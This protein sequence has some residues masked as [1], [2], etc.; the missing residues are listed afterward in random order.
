MYIQDE[1]LYQE[2]WGVH[3]FLAD[4]D[5]HGG[6]IDAEILTR[7]KI[8]VG[9]YTLIGNNVITNKILKASIICRPAGEH[10]ESVERCLRKALKFSEDLPKGKKKERYLA[11]IISSIYEEYSEEVENGVK[12][13]TKK[14]PALRDLMR[15]TF[16]QYL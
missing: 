1:P 12:I 2:G 4:G 10:L 3:V 7:V 16:P 9:R 15:K 6:F 13:I 11:M 5:Q 8:P 14:D